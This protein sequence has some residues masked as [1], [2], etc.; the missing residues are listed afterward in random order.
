MDRG[1]EE[2]SRLGL[3]MW[4]PS[5][6]SGKASE[7]LVREGFEFLSYH[8]DG[9]QVG[10]ARSA[11]RALLETVRADLAVAMRSI[12]DGKGKA[13]SPSM[14]SATNTLAALDRRIWG[15]ANSFS[16]VT[17]QNQFEAIDR[18]VSELVCT[19]SAKTRRV[20]GNA[21]RT[22]AARVLGVALTADVARIRTSPEDR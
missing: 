12:E 9:S 21:S 8:L 16:A 5:E 1:E 4:R 7:G 18:K 6:D 11:R 2:L 13:R 10:I 3:Q 15:W 17:R 19:F 20:E 22:E 14:P